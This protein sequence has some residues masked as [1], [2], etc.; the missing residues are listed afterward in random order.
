M[1]IKTTIAI[2]QNVMVGGKILM[3]QLFASFSSIIL[4]Q[5]TFKT[6]EEGAKWHWE[7]VRVSGVQNELNI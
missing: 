3:I 4:L 5:G 1:L 6:H 2:H 7:R